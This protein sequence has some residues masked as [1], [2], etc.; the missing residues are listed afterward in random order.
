MAV[1]QF[2]LTT[3]DGTIENWM[4]TWANT[5]L[6]NIETAK[7]Q[8][9][10]IT[11]PASSTVSAP[12]LQNANEVS[13]T[14]PTA[15]TAPTL[16]LPTTPTPTLDALTMSVVVPDN[17]LAALIVTTRNFLTGRLAGGTGLDPTI[18]A[19]LWNRG[20]DRAN[21]EAMVA[22][23]QMM[24]IR[25]ALGWSMP[26]GA[27]LAA[28][29]QIFF[30]GIQA[31]QDLNRDI[32]IEQAK[33]EQSNLQH[34][35]EQ[36]N[37]ALNSWLNAKAGDESNKLRKFEDLVEASIG[38]NKIVIDFFAAQVGSYE[39]TGRMKTAE[40]QV[41]IE[42]INSVNQANFGLKEF[43][44]KQ[45]EM[46]N[47]YNMANATLQSDILKGMSATYAQLAATFCNSLQLNKSWNF[48]EGHSE[49]HSF[50]NV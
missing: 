8:W 48:N 31:K 28:Y 21:L 19:A 7:T 2:P 36:L 15:P 9:L 10:A 4:M 43:S 26:Q 22:Y 32:T 41:L 5:S 40:A 37:A 42:K 27:D 34:T 6:T 3:S 49:S 39:A 29:Q 11:L 47:Q 44:I 1:W 33:L 18:E 20:R 16:S 46:V 25:G 45:I 14:L 38:L 13:L 17:D 35:I 30:K 23:D 50:D 12:T 24:N